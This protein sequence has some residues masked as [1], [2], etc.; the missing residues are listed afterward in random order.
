[1]L[2]VGDYRVSKLFPLDHKWIR[3]AFF[4]NCRIPHCPNYTWQT[5][6][7]VTFLL[8]QL[9][10]GFPETSPVQHST[11]HF[12]CWSNFFWLQITIER[13]RGHPGFSGDRKPSATQIALFLHLYSCFSRHMMDCSKTA[14]YTSFIQ[15]ISPAWPARFFVTAWRI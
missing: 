1:M 10:L 13:I 2:L 3:T 7:D 11:E 9:I 5:E 14:V 15:E 12:V 4:M 8:T 6:E